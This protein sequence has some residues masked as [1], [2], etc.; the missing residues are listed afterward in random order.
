[1]KLSIRARV[2]VPSSM[3]SLALAPDGALVA[4]TS[5]DQKL[6]VFETAGLS[7][8]KA[9]HLGTSFPHVLCFAPDGRAVAAGSKVIA[10]YDTTTWKKT[11][12]LKGHRHEVQ[13]AAFAP[14]GARVYTGSGNSFT[15][16]D[17]TV[18]AWDA[19]TGAA[20]WKWKA[21]REVFA[22]AA[23]P[24][25]RWV[26]A[27]ESSG[28]VSL[29]DA[30]TGAPR[31]ITPTGDWVY[32]LRYT[33]DSATVLATG[34]GHALTAFDVRSGSARVV[35]MASGARGFALTRDGATAIVGGT[36][37]GTAV[38]L[39]AIDVATGAVRAEGPALGRLPQGVELSPDGA[40]LYVLM[41]E[42]G[43]LVVLDVQPG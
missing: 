11:V 26:A 13:D 35:P 8:V 28:A 18:R 41:N 22:V 3:Y 40:T 25:G 2:P 9:V 42:P 15:P 30:A 39:T 16:A 31:W 5:S 24:D 12:A 1:M 10:L 7:L 21:T 20:L 29:L 17:W 23:S 34:D 19:A 38:P 32:C 6:R 36:Q 43:E 33:P 27:G 14:D 4:V 37:Y